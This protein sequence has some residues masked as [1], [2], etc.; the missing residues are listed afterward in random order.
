VYVIPNITLYFLSNNVPFRSEIIETFPSFI[1]GDK[2]LAYAFVYCDFRNPE[3]QNIANILGSLLG[4]LCVQLELFPENLLD[5][6]KSS[7]EN[8]QGSGPT[9]EMIS[10]AIQVLSTG[11]N[12][13]LFIDA[14]DEAGDFKSLAKTL[15]SLRTPK[16]RIKTLVT[17]RN[18][19]FIQR[20]FYDVRRI[21]LEHHM[22]D[23]DED[24]EQYVTAR[25]IIDQDL[26]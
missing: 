20:V 7:T 24:I 16:S 18:E 22:I 11:Q 1:A 26:E 23:I 25:L 10:E 19:V 14:M 2:P 21:S 12:V 6:Y 9:I 8:N 13:C 17:S 5:A 3:T 15:V 4:Q